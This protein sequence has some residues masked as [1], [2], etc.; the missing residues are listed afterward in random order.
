VT[1][2]V[3]AGRWRRG[4]RSAHAGAAPA[5]GRAPASPPCA[6]VPVRSG[7]RPRQPTASLAA[8]ALLGPAKPCTGSSRTTP[9]RQD[10]NSWRIAESRRRTA[11]PAPA[12]SRHGAQVGTDFGRCGGGDGLAGAPGRRGSPRGRAVACSV[13][14]RPPLAASISRK[15]SRCCRCPAAIVMAMPSSSVA[16]GARQA[17]I[18]ASSAS[19]R[20]SPGARCRFNARTAFAIA[21]TLAPLRARR[22]PACA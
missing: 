21:S 11:M 22:A 1:S 3:R 14:S 2:S 5:R 20:A 8:D 15:P 13:F 19:R 4:S 6:D 18:S 7:D 10:L 16:G 9:S 12:R 17:A